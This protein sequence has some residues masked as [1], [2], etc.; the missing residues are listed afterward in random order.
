MSFTGEYEYVD[1]MIEGEK[2]LIIE[3]DFRSEFEIARSTKGYNLVLQTLPT[4]F[5][6]KADRLDRIID[7]VMDAARLSLKKKGM[8]FPPWRRADYVKAKWLSPFTRRSSIPIP[9][10]ATS[11][12]YGGTGL[13]TGEKEESSIAK[14]NSCDGEFELILEKQC[15]LVEKIDKNC[16]NSQCEEGCDSIDE[17]M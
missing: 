13:L 7:I 15:S 9:L 11:N 17:A 3:I 1:V 12:Q 5:V 14:K 10:R 4:I 16:T 6:G 2:R 8:P